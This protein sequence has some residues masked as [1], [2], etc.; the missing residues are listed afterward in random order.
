MDIQRLSTLQASQE[1]SAAPTGKRKGVAADSKQA[2]RQDPVQISSQGRDSERQQ[3]DAVA[4]SRA[5]ALPEVRDDR[6]EQAQTRVNQGYYDSPEV[7]DKL[8]D[9][10]A[11][12]LTQSKS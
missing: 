5:T 6:V 2:Q 7:Q 1:A 10:L 8:A 12:S 9:T 4:T 11:R 3:A